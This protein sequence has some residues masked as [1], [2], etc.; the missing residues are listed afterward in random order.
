MAKD[1]GHCDRCGGYGYLPHHCQ[2]FEIAREGEDDWQECY[3][4]SMESALE[5]WADDDDCQGDYT[6]VQAGEDGDLHMLI[7]LAAKPE[8][9]KRFRV[10]GETVAKYHAHEA[11]K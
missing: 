7:R 1:W 2:L 3:S 5:A 10:F 9:V 6:I 8:E 4:V 11:P